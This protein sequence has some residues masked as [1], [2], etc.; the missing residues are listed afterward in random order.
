MP[1]EGVRMPMDEPLGDIRHPVSPSEVP[2]RKAPPLLKTLRRGAR[3]ATLV[4]GEI[5]VL[6]RAWSQPISASLQ[7]WDLGLLRVYGQ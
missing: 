6:S 1:A 5:R 3:F 7:P 4:A 2:S